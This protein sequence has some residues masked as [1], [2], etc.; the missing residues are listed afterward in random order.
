MG[1]T[2][3]FDGFVEVV[4]PL[5]E[6]EVSYLTDFANTRRMNRSNGPYFVKGEGNMGQDV[7][8]DVIH[9]YNDPDPSQPGLWCQW[10]PGQGGTTLEWDGGE[11]FYYS[12]KW[13][14]YLIQEFLSEDKFRDV[15]A[16]V[17]VDERFAQFT[18]DHVVNGTI[19][20]FGEDSEDRWDLVV[21]NNDVSTV[22][23]EYAATE[24]R[25]V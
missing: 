24:R 11:K 13:M 19:R 20:A 21:E 14:K 23:Y 17:A 9:N 22:E 4:P 12:A 6:A 2:T 16:M 15:A 1:Y 7:G 18:F 5:N 8:P 25:R 3:D 10:V